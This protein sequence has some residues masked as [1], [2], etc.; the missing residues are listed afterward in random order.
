MYKNSEEEYEKLVKKLRIFP[1]ITVNRQLH[2]YI[3]L[4]F[5]KKRLRNN[6]N[7]RYALACIYDACSNL[8]WWGKFYT[9][10]LFHKIC[11]YHDNRD[12]DRLSST[13]SPMDDFL[14]DSSRSQ[15]TANQE[16]AGVLKHLRKIERHVQG[17]SRSS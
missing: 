12:S 7:F 3:R 15:I 13:P 8:R 11:F 2:V 16:L 10:Y 6:Q 1:Y 9:Y 5:L 4:D 14:G 17:L